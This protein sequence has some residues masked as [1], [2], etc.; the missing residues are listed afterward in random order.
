MIKILIAQDKGKVKTSA[1]GFWRNN[2]GKLY[3]DYI[4]MQTYKDNN[5]QGLYEHLDNLKTFYNQECIFYVKD[6]VGYIYYSRDRIEALSQRVESRIY[7]C[8]K[9]IK[10]TKDLIKDYLSCYGGLTVYDKGDYYLF[11]GYYNP[12]GG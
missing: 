5:L 12:K 7:K 10:R 11:E 9:S 1:R 2:T 6:S 4:T 3:Y 8:H